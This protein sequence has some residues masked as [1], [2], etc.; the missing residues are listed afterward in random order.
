MTRNRLPAEFFAD[1]SAAIAPMY[2]VA[3]FGLITMAG[4][5]WDYSR[6]MTMD[7]ELQNAADQAA[8]AAATQLTGT[9]GAMA[10]AEAAAEDYLASA[11]SAW[12]NET[13][14][15][16]DGAGRAITG[17]TFEFYQSYDHAA[18]T[19]GPVAT[20]DESA[21]YVRVIV[22]GREAFYA[23]TAIGGTLSSGLIE[24]DAVATLETAVCKAPKMFICAPTREFPTAADKGRGFVL[25]TLPNATDAFTPGNFGFL[26]PGAEIKGE[27]DKGNPN[28]ELGKNT[29]LSGCISSTG[30]Q[31]EPGFVAPETR[32]INTRFDIYGPSVPSCNSSNGNFCPSQSTVSRWVYKIPVTGGAANNVATAACPSSPT[33]NADLMKLDDALAEMEAQTNPNP[34]YQRDNCQ[35]NG[36][37]STIGDGD[38]SGQDYMNR[39]HGS[40]DLLSV[41]DGSRHGVY[42]WELTNSASRL[43]VRKVGYTNR[44]GSPPRASLYCSYPQ[45]TDEDPW[46]PSPTQKDRRVM[47]VASVDCTGLNGRDALDVLR[48][49]DLF[50]VD[51]SAT[52]GPNAGEIMTEIVGPAQRPAVVTRSNPMAA[53][54]RY[55]SD[56]QTLCL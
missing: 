50:L 37:C 12:V 36:S 9:S 22:D 23:L 52:T 17:L 3:L 25:R 14:L 54:S 27:R 34:G 18:D 42:Q 20:N 28:H 21:R 46:V 47:T 43:G 16:N 56:D 33:N 7:S 41:S 2:A 19:P 55:W 10:A 49:V 8:L 15:S 11:D 13:K 35:L 44:S 26:D 38:W 6:L 32:A 5:G 30:I 51:A 45:P 53:R 48:W 29:E 40:T 4:V 39:N 1:R 31:S 24:A